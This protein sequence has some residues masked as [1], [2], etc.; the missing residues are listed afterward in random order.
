MADSGFNSVDTIRITKFLGVGRRVDTVVKDRAVI[1]QII[2]A[3]AKRPKRPAVFVDS[4]LLERFRLELYADRTL[5]ER[6]A[7]TGDFLRLADEWYLMN[8]TPL[9]RYLAKCT[10]NIQP[11]EVG[12]CCVGRG[13]E[14]PVHEALAL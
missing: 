12:W 9:R 3:I 10:A 8:R 14:L 2:G 6:I 4:P 1:R 5:L 7:V 13:K 11:T